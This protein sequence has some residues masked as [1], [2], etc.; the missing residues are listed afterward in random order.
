MHYNAVILAGGKGT[1][2]AP[3]TDSIPKPLA[4][5]AGRTAFERILDLLA[6][7]SV[8]DAAVTLGYKGKMIRKITHPRV[9]LTFFEEK[10]PLGTA[11]GVK[12][13]ESALA[14]T[15]IVMSGDALCDFDLKSAVEKHFASGA[16][17]TVLLTHSPF[18]LE[19]GCVTLD[20]DGFISR[21][22]EKPP[23]SKAVSDLVNSGIYIMSKSVL[24]LIEPGVPCDFSRDLFPKL[25]RN[26][27]IYAVE[28]DGYWCDIGD[29][30][31]YYRCNA[32]AFSGKV[33]LSS[34]KRTNGKNLRAGKGAKVTGSVIYDNVSIGDDSDVSGSILCEGVKI[35]ADCRVPDGCVVGAGAS[36]GDGTVL[37][38]GTRVDPGAK[39]N[40]LFPGVFASFCDGEAD[41]ACADGAADASKLFA[42]GYGAGKSLGTV[43]AAYAKGTP[44]TLALALAAGAAAAGSDALLLGQCDDA[45]CSFAA[46]AFD[47]DCVFIADGA[48][49]RMYDQLGLPPVRETERE[50][51][52]A[53]RGSMPSNTGG[54]IRDVSQ[55][56]SV[57]YAAALRHVTDTFGKVMT[58]GSAGFTVS[59]D[60][61]ELCSQLCSFPQL[62]CLCLFASLRRGMNSF[63]LPASMPLAL[64]EALAQRGARVLCY[65][66]TGTDAAEQPARALASEN[67]WMR[68]GRMLSAILGS[69]L[70]SRSITLSEALKEVPFGF[71]SANIEFDPD[72]VAAAARELASRDDGSEAEEGVRLR[73]SD[74]SVT[75]VPAIQGFRLF[76]E[77]T[78]A[79]TAR[80][81]CAMA[82]D[83]IDKLRKKRR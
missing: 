56:C 81:L 47:A 65:T 5:I 50:V 35:G 83:E 77:A 12:N 19:Y 55:A 70:E 40:P 38:P 41:C 4:L 51:I 15:F 18:V 20:A 66:R 43:C 28:C 2:L 57:R 46:K 22:V 31:A 17:C 71:S 32:D 34:A 63:A 80:E 37:E 75:V 61:T 8:T 39:V 49:V 76:A 62:L 13:A 26:E 29:L 42:L 16:R 72:R 9:K 7:N 54:K 82:A 68:D 23:V 79:E 45:V 73:F 48:K 27:R 21:F 74:G 59:E 53:A 25:M 64:R 1:R 14:D 3:L 10:E 6:D 52:S 30:N 60:G 78:A 11:G 44:D 58:D 67:G 24:D 69:Y 33:K 36:L